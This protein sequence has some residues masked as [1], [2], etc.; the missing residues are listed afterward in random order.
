MTSIFV[1]GTGLPNGGEEDLD[2]VHNDT[3]ASNSTGNSTSLPV[4]MGEGS[5]SN[6]TVPVDLNVTT[7]TELPSGN[8]TTTL[9]SVAHGGMGNVTTT[10]PGTSTP[11]PTEIGG[12]TTTVATTSEAPVVAGP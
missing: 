8:I 6:L 1:P 12:S 10:T 9:P 7:T 11:V 5:S 4:S 2:C 3:L